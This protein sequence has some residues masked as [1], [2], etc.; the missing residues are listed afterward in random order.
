MHHIKILHA[1]KRHCWEGN[2]QPQV[3][4]IQHAKEDISQIQLKDLQKV[5][6]NPNATRMGDII[7]IILTLQDFTEIS[8]S[9]NRQNR[10]I[11]RIVLDLWLCGKYMKKQNKTKQ[12]KFDFFQLFNGFRSLSFDSSGPGLAQAEYHSEECQVQCMTERESTGD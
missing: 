5:E 11:C 1:Q 2:L 7:K 3:L 9:E 12:D 4:Y 8:V 6:V 10:C